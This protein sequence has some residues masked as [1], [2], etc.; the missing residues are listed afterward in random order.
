MLYY[1]FQFPMFF[2]ESGLN[3][4][5]KCLYLAGIL[6]KSLQFRQPL[7]ETTIC[8]SIKNFFLP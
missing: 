1:R 6:F 3:K 2:K 4:N 8:F 7:K 5:H